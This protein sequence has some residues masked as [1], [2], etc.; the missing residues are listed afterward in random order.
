MIIENSHYNAYMAGRIA[1]NE[2]TEHGKRLAE[3]RKAAG[4][5]Q[6]EV[7]K[8]LGIPQRTLSFYE[9][10]ARQIPQNLVRPLA[11]LFGVAPEIILGLGE[12]QQKKR[13]PKS[14]LER[15]FEKASQLPK[16]KQ[17][18]IIKLLGEVIE[19]NA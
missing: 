11:E 12:E 17:E 19:N 14:R 9:R 2:G 16:T 4:L 10:E 18:L 7:A 13:G 6:V 1:K 3:L 8:E 5:T 15:M